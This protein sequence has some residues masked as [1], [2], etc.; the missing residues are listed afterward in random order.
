MTKKP[1]SLALPKSVDSYSRETAKGRKCGDAVWACAFEFNMK[2]NAFG[3][4]QEPIQ[5]MLSYTDYEDRHP[6]YNGPNSPHIN[7]PRYFIPMNSKGT[8][9]AWSKAVHIESRAY[10]DT[11]DKCSGIYEE[12][13]KNWI[14]WFKSGIA[15][16]K[17][18]I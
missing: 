2:K 18:Y 12:M 14:D 4:S 17:Q 7:H 11:Y 9:Y 10:A 1:N 15:I 3:L 13:V 8:G 6:E 16:C 5:G